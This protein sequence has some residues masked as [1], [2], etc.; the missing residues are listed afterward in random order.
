MLKNYFKIALRT[1]R[2]YRGYSL[3]N[4]GGLAL[5]MAC[6]LLILLYVSDELR[7]DRFH[8]KADQ[9]YR[10]ERLDLERGTAGNNTA[11]PVAPAFEAA[12]PEII[13]TVRMGRD[14]VQVT[15]EDVSFREERFY[16]TDSTLFDVFSFSLLRGDPRTALAKTNAVVITEAMAQKYFGTDDPLG[17]ILTV[18]VYDGNRVLP[19]E[20]TGVLENVPDHAHLQFD[21]L[22]SMATGIDIYRRFE[23][24]WGLSWVKTYVLLPEGYP[25]DGI[26]ERIPALLDQ[27]YGEG[28]SDRMAMHLQPL[29]RIH[30][31][32]KAGSDTPGD[33]AYVYLFASIALFILLLACINFMNL[34]TARSAQRSKE[35][36]MR[37]VLGAYRA[38]LAGQFM[39]ESIMLAG[40]ALLLALV[41]VAGLLPFFNDLTGKNLTLDVLG[42]G[43]FLLSLGGLALGVGVV[44]GSYPALF[45]SGFLP[46]EALKGRSAGRSGHAALLRKSLVVFQFSISIVLLIGTVVVHRQM[47]FLQASN[48]GF[49]QAQLLIIP[50]EDR[51]V[52][53]N[54]EP[55]KAALGQQAGVQQIA[56]ASEALPSR[57]NN[58][59]GVRWEDV[60][61]E[62][63]VTMHVVAV[64]YDFFE[65]LGTTFVEGRNFAE[66]FAT[67]ATAGFILNEAAAKTIGWQKADGKALNVGGREGVVVGV[68]EDFHYQSFHR[69]IAPVVYLMLPG[70][71]RA[72]PDNFIV[73]IAGSNVSGTLAGL[74]ATWEQF[75]PEQPFEEVFVD[76]AFA[77][78]Y[79][80]EQRFTQLFNAFTL[81]AVVVACLGLLG[82]SSFM[83]ERRTKEMG[84]RK[85][86]G[87]ST[88]RL[89]LLLSKEFIQ[90]VLVAFVV[91]MPLAY[92]AML[93]WLEE[94]AYRVELSWWMF[95]L[96]GLAA[97]VIAWLTV[98]Y[99][100]M[101]VALADPVKALRYE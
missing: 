62:E 18:K 101:K 58:S 84:V 59:W 70:T 28:T 61:E 40:L 33:I 27:Y 19:L 4:V 57:M 34:A 20:V 25:T 75:S 79:Q 43:F 21:F 14:P 64:D 52:Q 31:Y 24:M 88:Q 95:L 38:Q 36:G 77:S 51:S 7:F 98:G 1:L 63:A 39:G 2:R 56:M 53:A 80:A 50:V 66:A 26:A 35:V 74:K 54:M 30:L 10:I 49:D 78:L 22:A 81:L 42:N 11:Y 97:L 3:I 82:L 90:L 55:L 47:S 23:T 91:A 48:L 92:F 67:D 89:M 37:K 96:A 68:V 93:R 100:A 85:V 6:C 13:H 44:A 86:L 12:F 41:V 46:V 8:E 60:P 71:F 69:E 76:Q 73:R 45:L 15:R 99:H 65:M 9:I 83:A 87:A 5:G 72:S 17:Q 16:W 94:F 29:T 32:S